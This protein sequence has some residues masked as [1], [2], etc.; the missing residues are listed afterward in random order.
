MPRTALYSEDKLAG[1]MYGMVIGDSLGARFNEK[2]PDEIP[3]LDN[4]YLLAHP[5]KNY[6][7]DTQMAIS[8]LEE[9]IE[10]GEIDQG[11]LR[12]RMLNRFTP[13]RGYGGGMLEV[14]ERWRG[15][16]S[17]AS[18][19]SSLYNGSGNFGDGGAV[20]I[21]PIC[22]FFNRNQ[23]TELYEQI[24]RCV[25]LT[26]THSYGISGAVLQAAAVHLA[27]NDVPVDEWMPL[28]FKLPLES[29]F[30]IK[31]G[32]VQQCLE[33]RATVHEAAKDIG[34]GSEAI[35]AVPAAVFSTLRN[36]DSV[37]DTILFA[38]SMGG[39]CDTIGAMAGALAGARLGAH[40]IAP[41]YLSAVENE[42]EGL[43]FIKGLIHN[44]VGKQQSGL[45]G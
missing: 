43:D 45:S 22:C 42:H 14:I 21:A 7:D 1:L 15:G 18:T 25:L 23:F 20:R 2:E 24:H 6:T 37:I 44:A 38:V 11:S 10:H 39:D 9:M 40:T 16:E 4:D 3:L 33:N 5:P 12:K 31:L 26:H 32:R 17:I 30:K 13:W 41:A 27:L 8:V 34:N 36:I 35:E 28:L 29:A 19:A